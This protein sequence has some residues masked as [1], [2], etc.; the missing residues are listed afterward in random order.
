[1]HG[2][3]LGVLSLLSF[4]SELLLIRRKPMNFWAD[5]VYGVILSIFMS[6][7][8]AKI[9]AMARNEVYVFSMVFYYIGFKF[10]YYS[11]CLFNDK[12]YYG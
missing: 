4:V 8:T 1:M 10:D 12:E 9:I 11:L 5:T 7:L 3:D 6:A 2:F